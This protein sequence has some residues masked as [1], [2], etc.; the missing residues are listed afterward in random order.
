MGLIGDFVIRIQANNPATAIRSQNAKRGMRRAIWLAARAAW[1]LALVSHSVWFV[2]GI[3][4]GPG[5]SL[6]LALALAFFVL[7]FLDVSFLRVTWSRRSIV[8]ALVIVLFLHANV[9]SDAASDADL[10]YLWSSFELQYGVLIQFVLV[11]TAVI[12]VFAAFHRFGRFGK[13]RGPGASYDSS[14][15]TRPFLQIP[16]LRDAPLRAPPL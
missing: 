6:P 4:S 9:I 2:K 12:G 5:V 8:A 14:Q 1:L 15:L 10:I 7:K 13:I 16:A 11:L 3:V